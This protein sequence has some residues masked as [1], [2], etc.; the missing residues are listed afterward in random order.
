MQNQPAN[1]VSVRKAQIPIGNI[2]IPA[3]SVVG[4]GAV[5]VPG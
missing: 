1:R 3:S 5:P 4:M 2:F